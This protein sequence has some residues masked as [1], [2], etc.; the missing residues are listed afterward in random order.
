MIP[1]PFRRN[2]W[3]SASAVC[4]MALGIGFSTLLF[5]AFDALLLRPLAVKNPEQLV[6][7]GVEASSTHI[8]YEHG[9]QYAT[10]LAAR[11]RAFGSMLTS[12]PLDAAIAAGPFAETVNCEVVSASYFPS[13]GV[14][15]KQGAFFTDADTDSL[16]AVIGSSLAR[17]AFGEKNPIGSA[18]RVRGSSFTI[19]G[20]MSGKFNGIDLDRRT[21]VWVSTGAW[22]AWTGNPRGPIRLLLRLRDPA[23]LPMAEAEIKALHP[24]MVEADFEGLKGVTSA[25][26]SEWKKRR[27]ELTPVGAGV[28]AMRKQFLKAMNAIVG[29]IAM[30]LLLV[31][32]NVAGLMLARG[33]ARRREIAIRLSLGASKAS[34]F[35]SILG[36]SLLLAGC[37]LALGFFIVWNAQPLLLTFFPSRFPVNVDLGLNYRVMLF[38]ASAT[39][40][41]AVLASLA[42]AM[43][44]LRTDLVSVLHQGGR[45]SAPSW[46]RV[47]VL[48]QVALA[49]ILIAGSV[50][51]VSTLDELRQ[52]DPGWSPKG[53]IVAVIDPR[54]SGVRR[55]AIEATMQEALRKTREIPGVSNV[56]L[57]GMALMRGIG[58][59]MT[60]A[61]HGV[62]VTAADR[63][64]V[65]SNSVSDNHF[66]NLGMQIVAGRGVRKDDAGMKPKPVVVTESFAK[67]FFPGLD[68]LGRSFGRED[69]NGYGRDDCSIVGVVRDA[70]YRGMRE[71]APPTFFSLLSGDTD[72]PVLYIRSEIDPLVAMNQVRSALAGI[73]PGLAPVSLA[74]LESE[75]EMSMWQ[76]R[77]LA[78]LSRVFAGLA[79][80]IAG[81]G[82]FSLLAYVLSRRVR[83]VGIRMAV[84]A[85]P[86]RIAR[87]FAAYAAWAV[88]PGI[89]L[90]AAGF[91]AARRALEPILFGSGAGLS[92][93]LFISALVL[94]LVGVASI[95]IPVMRSTRIEPT[96]ALRQE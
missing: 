23:D 18:I 87:L 47:T 14:T 12:Y 92:N 20:V 57:A 95:L 39:L 27:T 50:G 80:L 26:I 93:P 30:L 55:D 8:Y 41:V 6:M 11:G 2:P 51:L 61:P 90:G 67:Q 83:E 13:L 66:S 85:T 89:A 10:V 22:K 24:A 69:E 62:K 86:V 36:E 76:E 73:G 32:A 19:T 5:T 77:L 34:V 96:V 31:A 16:P 56:S 82:L 21:D 79:A 29:A 4:L 25:Q 40:G 58:L 52:V 94:T 48:I 35:R 43:S 28:S 42:P 60:I 49:T 7:L 46:G 84:G 91:V 17:R 64:N 9:P 44:C 59:K 54:M 65:S 53:L 71:I 1:R 37:G 78:S 15:T 38:A 88:I 75:I 45:S 70:K 33:E 72:S 3:M 68:P 81:I 63:L 74:T